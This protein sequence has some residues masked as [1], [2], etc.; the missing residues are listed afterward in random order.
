[1]GAG[2]GKRYD[3]EPTSPGPYT[4]S[5]G[6]QYAAGAA[7]LGAGHGGAGSRLAANARAQRGLPEHGFREAS[8]TSTVEPF[9]G[10]Q[11]TSAGQYHDPYST[12]SSPPPPA[13]STY[14]GPAPSYMTHQPGS[15]SYQPQPMYTTYDQQQSYGG[16][17]T[18]Y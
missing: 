3:N 17:Q 1:V 4:Q 14:G 7:G 9:T 11:E 18:R 2:Y 13:P 16:N 8:Q 12:P 6:S 5:T 10:M 15:G